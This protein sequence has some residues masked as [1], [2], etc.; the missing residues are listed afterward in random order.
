MD[1]KT[2]DNLKARLDLVEWEIRHELHPQMLGSNKTYLPPAC[3]LTVSKEK[4]NFLKVLKQVKVPDG[5]A[6][7]LSRCIQLTKRNITGDH[8]KDEP[9][10]LASQASQVYYVNDVREKEWV[11]AVRTK[12]R[13]VYDVGNGESEESDAGTYYENEPYNLVVENIAANMNENL[14][15]SRNDA[16]GITIDLESQ[17]DDSESDGDV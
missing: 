7:N 1:G 16:D 11:I 13:D 3:V 14:H 9:F 15:W 5:Y 12:A 17:M 4:D 6:S 2:K 8:L 10:I